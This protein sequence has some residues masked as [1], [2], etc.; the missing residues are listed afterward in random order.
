[1]KQALR[2]R[3][4]QG[5]FFLRRHIFPAPG[6]GWWQEWGMCV[7]GCGAG[8]FRHLAGVLLVLAGVL[9]VFLCLPARFFVIA[10]G[11]A[12][13]LAGLLLLRAGA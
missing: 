12:L 1:M 9:L 11:V 2:P 5:F 8:R 13:T 10:L 4:P 3:W 6:I 7:G